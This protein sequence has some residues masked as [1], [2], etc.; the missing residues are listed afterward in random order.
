VVLLD[1]LSRIHSTISNGIYGFLDGRQS[2]HLS[3]LNVTIDVHPETFFIA[4]MNQGSQYGGTFR[5]DWAW[6]RRFPFTIEK[7]AP[8]RDEEV[9][10]LTSATGVDP[11]GA[12][13]LVDVAAKARQMYEAGDLRAPISTGSLVA[14]AWLVASGMSES[15]ALQYA[16]IPLFDGDSNGVVG[17]ESDR[18]KVAGI[19]SMRTGR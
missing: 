18:Q 11:D 9:R 6:R 3:D 2:V 19:L 13:V 5:L 14:A 4:T 8:P 15:D 12:S 1:D 16:V 7:Q 10:I 17:A